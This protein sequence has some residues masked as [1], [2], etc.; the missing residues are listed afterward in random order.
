M[1]KLLLILILQLGNIS[2]LTGQQP[3]DLTDG[4]RRDK[5]ISESHK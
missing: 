5:D 2:P 1:I 4:D 3:E